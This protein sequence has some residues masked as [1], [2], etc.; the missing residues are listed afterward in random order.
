MHS[1]NNGSLIGNHWLAICYDEGLGV[2]KNPKEAFKRYT[3]SAEQGFAESQVCLGIHYIRGDDVV[4]KDK[5]KAINYFIS[6]ANQGNALA[7]YC[8]GECYLDGSVGK[9]DKYK[10]KLW[11]QKAAVQGEQHA[12]EALK[13]LK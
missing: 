6:S 4:P 3:L 11:L 9:V 5:E 1:A 12:I 10:A 2:E 8:L 7:Q 13:K